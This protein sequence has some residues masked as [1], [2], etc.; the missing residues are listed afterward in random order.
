M[1]RPH[2]KLHERMR[3]HPR[4]HR[5]TLQEHLPKRKEFRR[6]YLTVRAKFLVAV[7]LSIAW[8]LFC[9]WLALPWMHDVAR[10]AGWPAAILTVGGIA[11]VPGLMNAFLAISLLLD[12]RPPRRM[13]DRYPGVSVLIAAFNEGPHIART[14]H[15][16]GILTKVRESAGQDVDGG[17]GQLR[18]RAAEALV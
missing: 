16:R 8:F 15:H 5:A 6:A 4:K 10:L 17:C 18:A 13:F 3:K 11:L 1:S 9:T 14:L 7:S 2:E 12:R